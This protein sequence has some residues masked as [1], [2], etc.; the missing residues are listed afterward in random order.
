MQSISR[1]STMLQAT[2]STYSCSD[3]IQGDYCCLDDLMTPESSPHRNIFNR[4]RSPV[5]KAVPVRGRA[6]GCSD[7]G[8]ACSVLYECR[9]CSLNAG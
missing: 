2:V 3:D 1:P 5:M 9:C 4:V 7:E 6:L 8:E